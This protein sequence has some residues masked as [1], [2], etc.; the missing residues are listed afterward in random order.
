MQ[1]QGLGYRVLIRVLFVSQGF[2]FRIW[3]LGVGCRGL[4]CIRVI[5]FRVFEFVQRFDE[6]LISGS[7][8]RVLDLGFR[9]K[10]QG[11]G[12]RFLLQDTSQCQ[13]LWGQGFIFGF[14]FWGFVFLDQGVGLLIQG[15]GLGLQGFQGLTFRLRVQCVA[16]LGVVF[17]VLTVGFRVQ[18]LGFWISDFRFSAGVQDLGF[19]L[20]YG[21]AF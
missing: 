20:L 19:S 6:L 5:G 14:G 3:G 8:F 9:F 10:I 1:V 16:F 7:G 15:L 2:G 11:F 12:F 17:L 21:L 13:E 4:G 18:G